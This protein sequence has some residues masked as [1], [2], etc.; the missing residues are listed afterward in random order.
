MDAIFEDEDILII[1]K[2][3]GQVVNRSETIK[4]GTLQDEVS[5]YFNLGDLGIGNRAG[6]VH[7]L[8]RETSGLMVIAKTQAAFEKLQTDFKLRKVQ[9]EY[10]ALVHGF[11]KEDIGLIDKPIG[12]VGGFGK[13]GV[14]LGDRD[15]LTMFEVSDRLTLKEEVLVTA[16]EELNKNRL[17]YIKSHGRE[18]TLVNVFPKTGRTHQIRVHFKSLSHPLVS[19]LIYG[20]KRLVDFDLKWCP[21]LFLH[22]KAISFKHPKTGVQMFFESDLPDD[23]RQAL[24]CL[25]TKD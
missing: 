5:K 11:V 22:A 19:D 4:E 8:D 18:F 25:T 24:G 14:V 13:F 3:S 9:K 6:I 17:R 21:R 12:R 10:M 1:E 20:P 7:R 23:L 2:P 16:S 15:A